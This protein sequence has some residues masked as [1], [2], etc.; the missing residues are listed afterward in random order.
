[1][2]SSSRALRVIWKGPLRTQESS[3]SSLLPV[4]SVPKT[5]FAVER[6]KPPAV[7][8]NPFG[9]D[10]SLKS[11]GKEL[12][13][14][15]VAARICKLCGGGSDD[16]GEELPLSVCAELLQLLNVLSAASDLPVPSAVL[17]TA[18]YHTAKASKRSTRLRNLLE[19]DREGLSGF[20]SMFM[21]IM[22]R[23]TALTPRNLSSLALSIAY[24]PSLFPGD[25]P[26]EV[27]RSVLKKGKSAMKVLGPQGLANTA[28]AAAVVGCRGSALTEKLQDD[29]FLREV[30]PSLEGQLSP[31]NCANLVWALATLGEGSERVWTF[32]EKEIGERRLSVRM[33]SL[34]IASTCW[35]FSSACRGEALLFGPLQDASLMRCRERQMGLQ[36]VC[37]I[38]GAMAKRIK[39]KSHT[40]ACN[41]REGSGVGSAL[42]RV[43][44][45]LLSEFLERSKEALLE[46]EEKMVTPVNISG[47]VWGFAALGY[48]D[49]RFFLLAAETA[50]SNMTAFRPSELSALLWGFA[51]SRIFDESLTQAA[52]ERVVGLCREGLISVDH[53]ALLAWSFG[54]LGFWDADVFGALA[55]VAVDALQ[56][57]GERHAAVN[58]EARDV[59]NL[60]WGLTAMCVAGISS[61][62][63]GEI[64]HTEDG[65]MALMK[66]DCEAGVRLCGWLIDLA[67]LWLSRCELGGGGSQGES[68]SGGGFGLDGRVCAQVWQSYCVFS[69]LLPTGESGV[70]LRNARMDS[71]RQIAGLEMQRVHRSSSWERGGGAHYEVYKALRDLGWSVEVEAMVDDLGL[72]PIDLLVKGGDEGARVAVEVDGPTHFMRNFPDRLTGKTLFRNHLL[73][74]RGLEVLSIRTEQWDRV[75]RCPDLIRQ[76]FTKGLTN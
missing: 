7:N 45:D 44:S 53:A 15:D 69:L 29:S 35:A 14:E 41:G 31:Q 25:K 58:L 17:T 39:G 66:S 70:E 47:S 65:S 20:R 50:L 21:T 11:Q 33:K 43:R 71:L 37:T 59:G 1:M 8:I 72:P 26:H 74:A 75:S 38:M 46:G 52:A 9:R 68:E 23:K 5:K 76:F 2:R 19:E 12:S 55:S 13:Y 22:A 40:G 62:R 16:D 67:S 24:A 10:L 6:K 49:E 18:L 61:D 51:K 27:M 36:E 73:K 28:Y 4:R 42:P 54:C 60:V 32:V 34:E 48:V 30:L 64:T 63:K 56:L 3:F 57:Q